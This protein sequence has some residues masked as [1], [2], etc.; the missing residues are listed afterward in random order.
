M[1][2]E[3]IEKLLKSQ[4]ILDKLILTKTMEIQVSVI[5]FIFDTLIELNQ[6]IQELKNFNQKGQ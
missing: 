2:T 6:D 4:E 1:K 5:K 3:T